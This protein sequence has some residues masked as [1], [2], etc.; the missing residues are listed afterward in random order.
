MQDPDKPYWI[1]FT[2]DYVVFGYV[3]A[4][5][6]LTGILFGLVPAL[7]V[8]KTNINEV[9]K[10]GGRGTAGTRRVRWLSGIM[11]VVE[12]ALTIVLLAGAGL[13][14]RSFLKLYTLDVGIRTEHLMTMRMELPASKIPDPGRAPRLLRATRAAAGRHPRSGS[15][16]CDHRRAA[17]RQRTT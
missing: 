7:H 2:V 14:I 9:L 8:S 3:A 17:V 6:V 11:V 12:L 5:C 1:A 15:D 4:I 10:E 13:M 16:G